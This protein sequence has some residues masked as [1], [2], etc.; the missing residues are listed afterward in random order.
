MRSTG[1][2]KVVQKLEPSTSAGIAVRLSQKEIKKLQKERRALEEAHFGGSQKFLEALTRDQQRQRR[3]RP[4]PRT[5]SP[6]RRL[7][8]LSKLAGGLRVY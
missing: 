3:W 7:A 8:P 1:Y 6:A 4:S 5:G 2:R